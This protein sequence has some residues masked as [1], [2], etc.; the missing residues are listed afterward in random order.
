MVDGAE[1]TRAYPD[2]FVGMATVDLE[3]PVE[4]VEMLEKAVC[5]YGFKGLKVLGTCVTSETS[6]R[7]SVTPPLTHTHSQAGC[8]S[9]R[10][11]TSSTTRSTVRWPERFSSR[12][13][14]SS[15]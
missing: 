1:Y 2:R 10:P 12:R 15:L 6:L 5:E 8:G 7:L 9:C 11:T 14:A 3:K 4:A 13:S